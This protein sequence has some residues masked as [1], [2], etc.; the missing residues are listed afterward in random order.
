MPA[1]VNV[2]L[3]RTIDNSYPIRIGMP[4]SQAAREI[5][6]GQFGSHHFVITDSTVARL[7]GRA[8]VKR[9][10]S[11]GGH[12]GLIVVPA[13]ERS[14]NRATKE[15]I[16]DKLLAQH[17]GR[18]CVIIALGGGMIGDL[19]GFVAAT[20]QRGVP[21]IQIPT[22]L[23]SQVDSSVGGKVAVDHPLGKNLVGAFYQPKQV[24]IDTSTLSTLS[25]AEFR[26][27]MAEVIKIAAIMDGDLFRYLE[28]H[29][30]TIARRRPAELEFLIRRSCELK[31]RVVE[32]DEKEASFRRILNFGHTIGHALESLSGYR[33]SHGRAVAIGMCLEARISVAS[34]YLSDGDLRRLVRLVENFGLPTAV[35]RSLDERK[36]I[37]ATRHDK[38]HRA[39]SLHYTLLEQIGKGRPGVTLSP[40]E[41]LRLLRT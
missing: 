14:K 2:R 32:I 5:V 24:Y 3:K 29:R 23:L 37:Q 1:T 35:P 38:K 30:A 28:Q 27:G 19:A 18:D 41:V 20:F 36:I 21:L 31:S 6:Q 22:T 17:A 9:L 15:R 16:E 12:A 8:F 33:M 26:D 4:L 34:G 40:G 7:Y 13:G 11:L 39:G 10:H 25:D